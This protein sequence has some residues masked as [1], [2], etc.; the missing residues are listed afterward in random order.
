MKQP[1][2]GPISGKFSSPVLAVE[3]GLGILFSW[4]AVYGLL[5][6]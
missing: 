5:K 1:A 3:I 6:G 4:L 2:S